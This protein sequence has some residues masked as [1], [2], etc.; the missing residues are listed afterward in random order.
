MHRLLLI[1]GLVLLGSFM[2]CVWNLMMKEGLSMSD[3]ITVVLCSYSR[4]LKAYMSGRWN[5]S[6][7]LTTVQCMS[8][9]L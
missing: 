8:D 1:L 3:A 7:S 9:K 6:C 4:V 2:L 5:V